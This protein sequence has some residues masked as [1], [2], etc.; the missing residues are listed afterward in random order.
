M[1]TFL[2]KSFYLKANKKFNSASLTGEV[3][4]ANDEEFREEKAMVEGLDEGLLKPRNDST[5]ERI[6]SGSMDKSRKGEESDDTASTN[7]CQQFNIGCHDNGMGSTFNC[8]SI[9]NNTIE[10]FEYRKT[11][12]DQ[13]NRISVLKEAKT[14]Y[15]DAMKKEKTLKRQFSIQAEH[16]YHGK[17][18]GDERAVKRLEVEGTGDEEPQCEDQSVAN[19]SHSDWESGK[20]VSD[21]E[22]S[23]HLISYQLSETEVGGKQQDS[24]EKIVENDNGGQINYN[25][26]ID[27]SDYRYFY[28]ENN[29]KTGSYCTGEYYGSFRTA[30][31]DVMFNEKDIALIHDHRGYN[32]Q[33]GSVGGNAEFANGN[34]IVSYLRQQDEMFLIQDAFQNPVIHKNI[35]Q[36]IA[37]TLKND[38]DRP[39]ASYVNYHNGSSPKDDGSSNS[40]QETEKIGSKILNLSHIKYSSSRVSS[41]LSGTEPTDQGPQHPFEETPAERMSMVGRVPNVLT[42]KTPD[43]HTGAYE[44][45][46]NER[47]SLLGSDELDFENSPSPNGELQSLD[48]PPTARNQ[49]DLVTLASTPSNGRF[50]SSSLHPVSSVSVMHCLNSLTTNTSTTSVLHTL[51]PQRDMENPECDNQAYQSALRHTPNRLAVMDKFALGEKDRRPTIKASDTMTVTDM[52]ALDNGHQQLGNLHSGFHHDQVVSSTS[53]LLHSP[54][55]TSSNEWETLRELNKLASIH[56]GVFDYSDKTFAPVKKFASV[57]L[58]PLWSPVN[59]IP[60]VEEPE[61]VTESQAP[62]L[63]EACPRASL[64]ESAYRCIP[65]QSLRFI[66]TS[67]HLVP[68]GHPGT[69]LSNCLFSPDDDN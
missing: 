9:N 4:L 1:K 32:Y 29:Y 14:Y 33:G 52:Y 39:F 51:S 62:E 68:S 64:S 24:E 18:G 30:K 10:S 54:S 6:R 48:S 58:D 16:D 42:T 27:G 47:I 56:W 17:Y 38:E 23:K 35:D 8:Q 41:V 59:D 55:N 69:W 13:Q 15:Q 65:A 34:E 46:F 57:S 49:S 7:P 45:S 11:K 28:N 40:S 67:A 22:L 21:G 66:E 50:D 5:N 44:G 60:A 37:D 2:A 63:I 61:N 31:G 26:A 36:V 19:G 3:V 12:T 53:G 20:D 43:H 25:D